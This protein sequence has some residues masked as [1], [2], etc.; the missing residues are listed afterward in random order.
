MKPV[1]LW[2]DVTTD[3][4]LVDALLAENSENPPE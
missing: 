3:D 4:S 1:T 2:L